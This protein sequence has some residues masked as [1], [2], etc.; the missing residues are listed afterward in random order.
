MQLRTRLI[1]ANTSLKG[2]TKV[3]VGHEIGLF[4]ANARVKRIDEL[5]A[6][7]WL[8]RLQAEY[9]VQRKKALSTS[10]SPIGTATLYRAPIA[11]CEA[12]R[13]LPSF[14]DSLESLARVLCFQSACHYC[15]GVG[16]SI[17]YR[18]GFKRCPTLKQLQGIFLPA[19]RVPGS[20]DCLTRHKGI[21]IPIGRRRLP[22]SAVEPKPWERREQPIKWLS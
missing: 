22:C 2:E 7:V 11:A 17:Q 19:V 4:G 20:Q 14:E 16:I 13:R 18:I 3:K 10:Y 6:S 9:C 5:F 1:V 8:V 12:V 21:R 15:K